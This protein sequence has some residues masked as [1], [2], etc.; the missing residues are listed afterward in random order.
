MYLALHDSAQLKY[1]TGIVAAIVGAAG[2][3]VIPIVLAELVGGVGA[4]IK[5]RRLLEQRRHAELRGVLAG[6]G[7]H[8][9][10]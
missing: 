9:P 7:L 8:P 5:H 4:V 2:Q 3:L 6:V 10:R 1:Q